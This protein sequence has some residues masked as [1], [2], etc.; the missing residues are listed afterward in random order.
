MGIFRYG[1]FVVRLA[2]ALSLICAVSIPSDALAA[3]PNPK[4][5]QAPRAKAIPG[6]FIVTVNPSTLALPKDGVVAMRSGPRNAFTVRQEAARAVLLNV[7]QDGGMRAMAQSPASNPK[8]SGL[9]ATP[10]IFA[11]SGLSDSQ[12]AKLRAA[13]GI[14]AVSQSY[15]IQLQVVGGGLAGSPSLLSA[16]TIDAHPQQWAIESTLESDPVFDS[17]LNERKPGPDVDIDGRA[18]WNL[19]DGQGIVVAVVDTG[20]EVSHPNL[21]PNVYTNYKEK[22]G[23]GVDDDANGFIDDYRGWSSVSGGDVRDLASHGT[24]VAGI[25]A[26]APRAPSEEFGFRLQGSRIRRG[27]SPFERHLMEARSPR[28]RS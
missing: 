17:D 20:F 21:S 4:K 28:L 26:A 9:R 13:K 8:I 1:S 15:Q 27:F 10:D 16:T 14:T 5:R 25:I 12:V 23:N 22:P 6:E 2:C 3:R 18:A 7:L 24:H 11:V 19:A